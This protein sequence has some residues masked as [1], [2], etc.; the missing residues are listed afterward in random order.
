MTAIILV[1]LGIRLAVLHPN[2]SHVLVAATRL[3]AHRQRCA[4]FL[5]LHGR[6]DRWFRCIRCF[7]S[8]SD[9]DDFLVCP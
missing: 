2:L 1:I 4:G 9:S 5:V 6:C 8:N 3:R 7:S